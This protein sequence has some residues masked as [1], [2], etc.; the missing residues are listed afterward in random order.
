MF[1][2]HYVDYIHEGLRVAQLTASLSTLYMSTNNN[3]MC[4]A[5]VQMLLT[6]T[7]L[8]VIWLKFCIQPSPA[9]Q[10]SNL[11]WCDPGK[12]CLIYRHHRVGG[13]RLQELERKFIRR[14]SKK[15]IPPLHSKYYTSHPDKSDWLPSYIPSYQVL[16]EKMFY[17]SIKRLTHTHPVIYTFFKTLKVEDQG[18]FHPHK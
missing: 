8:F 1:S 18:D 4:L 9:K 3:P 5:L 10:P 2:V 17:R 7:L 11:P 6:W 12:S 16:V 15:E 13:A 14:R